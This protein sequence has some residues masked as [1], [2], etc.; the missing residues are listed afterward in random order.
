MGE[1]MNV[2]KISVRILREKLAHGGYRRRWVLG[3]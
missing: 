1:I 2:Y 3:I